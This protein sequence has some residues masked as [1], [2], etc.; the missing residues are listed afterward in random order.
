MKHRRG[1]GLTVVDVKALDS[2]GRRY[3]VEVQLRVRPRLAARILYT[4][5]DLYQG[6]LS[7]GQDYDRLRPV[8][9]VWILDEDLLRGVPGWHHQFELLERGTGLCL[10][11]HLSIH[12][13]ELRKWEMPQRALDP[14]EEWVYFLREA[15]RWDKLPSRL[16]SPEMQKA[17]SI[18]Y[19]ISEKERD[20]MAYQARMN[21]QREMRTLEKIV[22]EQRAELEQVRV[23]KEQ[24]A[25]EREQARLETEHAR[26]AEEHARQAEEQARQA[27]QQAR[28]AEEHARVE[29]EQAES[30][31]QRLRARLLALGVDP[32]T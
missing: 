23:E 9:S 27:E 6:Q 31:L 28:Q 8:V 12:T 24:A 1:D 30:E 3:Q 13:V 25:A 20:Y 29:K 10:S 5:A 32:N 2:R 21:Y 7:E 14:G 22:A 19:E 18:L 4:W 11:E 17:M 15:R 26:Q 16:Q